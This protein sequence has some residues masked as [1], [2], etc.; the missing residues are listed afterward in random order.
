M[1]GTILQKPHEPQ[2]TQP[3]AASVAAER[4]GLT[5]RWMTIIAAAGLL[6]GM[7]FLQSCSTNAKAGPNGGDL[8]TLDD[9]KTSAEVM[10]NSG[11]GEAMVHTWNQDL[12]SALPIEATALTLGTEE[13]SVRLDPHPIASDPPGSCSRFY[14]RADWLQGGSVHH[15]WLSRTGSQSQRQHF[16]WNRCWKAGGAHGGMWSEMGGHGPGMGGTG[17]GMGQGGHGGMHHE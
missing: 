4:K 10:A 6:A 16:D 13:N 14:G 11:T 2:Q 5:K 7:P 9:G 12:K 15:G 8:V 3:D 1:T 17:H